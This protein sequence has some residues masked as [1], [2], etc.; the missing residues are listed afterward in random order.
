M[1]KK[2]HLNRRD[3]K[4]LGVCAGIADYTGWDAT[5]IRVGAVLVTIAGAFPWTVIA[6]ALAAW[7][8]RPARAAD[9]DLP[10]SG[11]LSTYEM[12]QSMTEIDRRMAEVENYVT[13]PNNRLA[14]EIESL[15]QG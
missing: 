8:A 5:W 11:R 3:G 13:S 2:F 4:L 14:R 1:R 7:L 6:Y 12:K 10:R 15:R 9:L